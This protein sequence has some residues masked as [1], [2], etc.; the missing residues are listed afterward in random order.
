MT[1]SRLAAAA[2]LAC[3]VGPTSAAVVGLT[4]GST[5]SGTQVVDAINTK[6]TIACPPGCLG[7]S[8][9]VW[10]TNAYTADSSI[11][12]AAIHAGVLTNK[13]GTI[14]IFYERGRVL[15]LGTTR[16]GVQSQDW[17]TYYSSFKFTAP[18][19][20]PTATCDDTSNYGKIVSPTRRS[21]R[22]VCP[23][24]CLAEGGSLYGTGIYTSDSH[25]CIAA[26]HSGVIPASGGSFMIYYDGTQPSYRAGR[27]TC[28]APPPTASSRSSY[29]SYGPSFRFTPITRL[30]CNSTNVGTTPVVS[31][32]NPVQTVSCPRGCTAK[33]NA[34]PVYG[35]KVYA[36]SSRIC[37]AAIHAGHAGVIDLTGGTFLLRFEKG[38]SSYTGSTAYGVT[39]L[40]F[41]AS[42]SSFRP[43]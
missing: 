39:S 35:T 24:G 18:A 30:L 26:I 11:C 42:P 13:G 23:G 20:P 33:I 36:R 25:V 12:R 19:L 29:G 32:A 4:C 16:N 15:Y 22:L 1:R 7:A 6:G 10:G 5:N 40:N 34:G 28:Q 41:V 3:L 37:L 14:P 43:V 27:C 38:Q 8:S 17:G 9:S 21:L 31:A 2:A